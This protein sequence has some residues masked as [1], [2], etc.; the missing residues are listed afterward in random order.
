MTRHNS[1]RVI[2]LA[3]L[4]TVLQASSA[5][6]PAF[7]NFTDL[8]KKHSPAVVNISTTQKVKA[9]S[10]PEI[11][12]DLLPEF[13]EGSPFGEFF[14]RFFEEGP[15][16]PQERQMQ[17][18]GS[19]FM[20]SSDGY[21][22]TSA[23]VI[24]DADEIIVRLNDSREKPAR[25]VG[26]DERTDVAL[27]KIDA[28][29]LP[30]LEIGNSDKLQ[31]G[32]WVLAIGSPFGLEHTATQGIVSAV[33]R[34]LPS[35]TYVPFIQTDVAVNPGN[36][37][38][39]LFNTDGQVVGINAQIY[40]RSGGYMGLSFAIPINVAMQ[41][42]DQLK[43]QGYVTR[44]WL[45][46]VIQP[47]TQDLAESFGLDR[48]RGALVARVVP[49]SPAAKAGFQ[50]GDIILAYD[51]TAIERS[52]ELPPLVGAT[53]IGKVVPVQ[54]V[55]DGKERQFEVTIQVL[56]EG[57][58]TTRAAVEDTKQLNM[59]VTELSTEK[60][61]E[62]EIGERGILVKKVEEGPAA[63][64]GIRSGDILLAID[65]KDVRNVREFVKIV[66]DLPKGKP[67]PILVQRGENPLFLA[68]TL[69][70]G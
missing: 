10:A 32:E 50:T 51:G 49:D 21:I 7:P 14:K 39:P 44:G 38:G 45:G 15:K 47:V 61:K 29:D 58:P 60:R 48:P 27:L 68:L 46:V 62:L 54:I 66:K 59:V 42:A 20:I 18:L 6:A 24:K 63:D 11:P 1:V 33:G 8:V 3:L 5:A 19:G 57:Q 35:D 2:A 43:S 31:V 53:P 52:G 12:Q 17:S 40:T 36:S 23:H 34:N 25:V 70:K 55:R 64:A 41:V 56:A 30:V 65:R 37:G 22:L 69:P 28:D 13:P 26:S 9:R 4:L 67:V 16:V